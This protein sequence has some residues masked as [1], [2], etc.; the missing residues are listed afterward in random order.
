MCLTL[1]TL[2]FHTLRQVA[3]CVVNKV[4]HVHAQH[5]QNGCQWFVSDYKC[6]FFQYPIH[7]LL[8]IMRSI[9]ILK[10]VA[11]SQC[12]CNQS[13][14]NFIVPFKETDICVTGN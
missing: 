8:V 9:P 13:F 14:D 1:N 2:G 10:T 11:A 4:Q 12:V 3:L 6:N 7:M 5:I